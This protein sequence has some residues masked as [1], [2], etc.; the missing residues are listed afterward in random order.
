MWETTVDG[1]VLHFHLAGINNQNFI[2]RD[3]ETGT[4]WQQVSGKA[5]HG[6][7]QGRQLKQVFHDEVSFAI[8]KRESPQGRVLKP[9]E[10]IA[11]TNQ[12]ETADWETRVGR[13]RAVAGTDVDKRLASRT[14]VLGIELGRKSVAYPLTALQKQ[15]P[16]MDTLGPVPIMLV[17]GEDHRSARAFERTLDGRRLE[18]FQKTQQA[19]LQLVDAE[20]GSTWNFE[21]KAIAG[22]L[23]G[24]QLKKVFVLEDYWFDWRIYHP[25]T[26][27]YEIGPR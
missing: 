13:M 20:T 21:G 5:I 25:D 24:R 2:M 14:L 6:P 1:R 16:I 15:S 18:F 22:P 9:V 27:I 3:E 26:T 4:W 7:L 19:E 8:W 17:L 10:Q 12:Y 11:A 23:A